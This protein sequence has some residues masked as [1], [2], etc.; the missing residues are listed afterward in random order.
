M[1]DSTLLTLYDEVR[2]KTLEL[3]AG[4]GE[5]KSL[6]APPG[7]HN[8]IR[9]H[10]GH[11][12]VVVEVLCAKALETSPQC[13]AGWFELFSW[14]SQP[15]RTK[16]D[17]WPSLQTVIGQL[18]AQHERLRRTLGSLTPE[19]LSSCPPHL[20]ESSIRRQIV[21][22]LHDEASH[23]G[24]IWLLRKMLARKKA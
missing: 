14:E 13:P 19:V 24:E 7:L 12:Y 4:V 1:S 18:H 16:P 11:C 10:A 6:C 9:W 21:H 8:S 2:G 15:A 23:G 5:R 17:R 20:G 22:A 3:L